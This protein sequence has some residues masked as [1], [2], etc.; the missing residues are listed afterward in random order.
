M[1]T[2]L[3]VLVNRIRLMATHVDVLQ[4]GLVVTVILTP[5]SALLTHV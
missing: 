1:F 3:H 4:D 5:M 2:L